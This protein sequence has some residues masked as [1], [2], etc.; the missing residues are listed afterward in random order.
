MGVLTNS[1]V[2]KVAR[3]T[4]RC[5]ATCRSEH[6]I[7][8]ALVFLVCRICQRGRIAIL[9]VHRLG[10]MTLPTHTPRVQRHSRQGLAIGWRFP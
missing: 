3:D 10:R 5:K 1:L 7:G 8:R 2:N 6:R 4:T 9:V